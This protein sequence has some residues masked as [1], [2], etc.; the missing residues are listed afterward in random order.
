MFSV[1]IPAF[2]AEKFIARS[3]QSVLNQ[4]YKDF[5]LIIIDDGSKDGTKQKISEFQNAKIK[6]FYQENA[7]VSAARNRGI[8]ASSHDYVC[9]LDADDEWMSDHLDVLASLIEKYNG[10]GLYVTGYD[11]R[12]N[13]GETIHKS[14]QILKKISDEDFASDD[15]FDILNRNGYFLNTNTVCIKREVF[16]NVGLFVEGV[17]NGEDDDMWFR[18]FSYYPLAVSK[19][20]TTT[21]DRSGCGAT[22][23]REVFES[24]FLER[25]DGLLESSEVPEHRKKSL[26]VWRERHNLSQARKYILA[27]EKKKAAHIFRDVSFQKVSK[28]KYFETLL[29]LF[30]PTRFV[31]E[32]IDKRD[33]AYY[34]K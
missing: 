25:V 31:R 3:I 12:L 6:Y 9:F 16:K 23:Q 7:G 1:V 18:I 17:K 33:A 26:I 21:Y 24:T 32:H 11:L 13:N 20:I 10:C 28:K 4:T 22:G 30:L 8:Q 29:C 19:K 14:Q 5:E 15:G 2:N 27:G 34:Q